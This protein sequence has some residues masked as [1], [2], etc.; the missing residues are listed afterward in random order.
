[1]FTSG[2]K[3]PNRGEVVYRLLLPIIRW[4]LHVKKQQL[5]ASINEKFFMG[6]LFPL[7]FKHLME[8][9]ES[10]RSGR[11]FVKINYEIFLLDGSGFRDYHN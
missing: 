8:W 6:I 2:I 7:S 9:G 5:F 10:A 1:M 11:Y 4:I 3:I